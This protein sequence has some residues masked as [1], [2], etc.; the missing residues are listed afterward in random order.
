MPVKQLERDGT[1]GLHQTDVTIAT[2]PVH[3]EHLAETLQLSIDQVALT[4]LPRNDVLAREPGP[5]EPWLAA[6]TAGRPLVV[7][8]PTFR[9]TAIGT[10]R[11]DGD[12]IGTVTQFEG[13]DLETIDAVMRDLG[14][15]CL[16]KPHPLAPQPEGSSLPN[17]TVISEVELRSVNETTLYNVLAHADVLV[18][19]HSS[20]W[21]DFLLTR[22]PILFT[23]SDLDAYSESRGFYFS[24]LEEVLPG[25]VVTDMAQLRSA[26]ES[27]LGDD[28]RWTAER[29]AA[30]AMHHSNVDA[31]SADRVADLVLRELAEL[32]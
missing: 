6:L 18:T 25:P 23:I 32:G 11:Q 14:A 7:W 5:M 29:E 24:N 13:A 19:D 3:A 10:P 20:V 16:I 2:A 12:D 21:I 4:G 8:L 26:L 30:L 27:V 22:R 31:N 1:V 17:V 28:D 15:H 9:S